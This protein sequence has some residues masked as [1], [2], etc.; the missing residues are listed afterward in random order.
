MKRAGN[1]YGRIAAYDN[2]CLAFWKAARGKRQRPDV[3]AFG[4]RFQ[5]NIRKLQFD[6]IHRRPEVGCYHFFE[7]RDP[8][9]RSICAAAFPERVLH[10]AV[11][12]V[13]EPVLERYAINDSY[14]CRKGKGNRKALDRA[15]VFA[16]RF[17]WY[18]KL[19]IKKYFDSI[20]HAILLDLL[21]RRFKDRDL[22]RLFRTL[23]DTYQ[24]RPG[25][26]LPIGNLVSQ[27][28]ANFYL[29]VFDHW[30]K[31]ELRVR[32]YLRYMDDFILF[33]REKALLKQ[34]LRRV[35]DFLKQRLALDLN[36]NVQL[37]RCAGGIPFLGYRVFPDHIRL[38]P[39]SRKRFIRRFKQYES[40]WLSGEWSESD[41]ARHME[42]LVDFT[43]VARADGFR[44]RVIAR[45]GVPS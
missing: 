44:R 19:D 41:L 2:L 37:N 26:G 40:R 28:L 17:E 43:R 4:N 32:G 34:A 13:C 11:M 1:L 30:V 7:I 31:E 3:I 9:P 45:F 24:T 29:G 36:E 33:G 12:N 27:H 14:A 25:K 20:D 16:R 10:H 39:R 5:A 21:A 35:A 23:L 6:L 8:K 18:L 22:L 42:P 38:A 15:R